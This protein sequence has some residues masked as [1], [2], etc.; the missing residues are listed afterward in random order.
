MRSDVSTSGLE[1]FVRDGV[2]AEASGVIRSCLLC[3][4]NVPG[5]MIVAVEV[6]CAIDY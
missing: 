1:T 3:I 6:G 2:K 5:N 4:A